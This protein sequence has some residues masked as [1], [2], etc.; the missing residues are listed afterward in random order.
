MAQGPT[1]LLTLQC[2]SGEIGSSRDLL[3]HAAFLDRVRIEQEQGHDASA[4]LAL[5]AYVVARLLDRLL[6]QEDGTDGRGDFRWQLEAVRRHVRDLAAD[7][8]EA[9]HLRGI[10]EAVPAAGLP[11]PALRISLTAYAYFLEHEARLEEALEV[12]S[13]AGRSQ[14]QEAGLEDSAT[15]ALFAGR[16]NR[17]LARWDA[18]N[19]CYTAA[20]EAALAV[21]N[22]VSALRGRLGRGAVHRGRGNFPVARATAEGV[23]REAAALNFPEVEALAYADLGTVLGLQGLQ[24][25]ALEANYQA[26]LL[27]P[28][29]MQRMRTLGDLGLGLLE[30]GAYDV[31][32]LAF[33]IVV[34]SPTKLL[35]RTN[36]LLELMDLESAV[37][38]RLAFQRRRSA[39]GEASDRMTPSMLVD[40]RFKEGVGLARFGQLLRARQSLQRGLGLAETHR[41]NSW[42]FRIERVLGN[43]SVCPDTDLKPVVAHEAG[44][45]PPVKRLELGLREYAS[46]ASA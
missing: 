17:L 35:V 5:A 23:A 25:E 38:N 30:I 22:Q 9:A 3:S 44:H 27:T 8:P 13:L 46:L 14:G 39:A 29:P 45:A 19:T 11:T 12:L 1:S 37:G 18:A 16:L 34:E 28:N 26:F 7:A 6:N 2:P 21:G 20:E 24:L 33:E 43:L 31:A 32:R 36:A 42:Y 40:F 10:A 41:L 15:S 4:Q